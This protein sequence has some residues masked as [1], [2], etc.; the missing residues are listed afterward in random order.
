MAYKLGAQQHI[1][2]GTGNALLINEV[3]QINA[4]DNKRKQAAFPQYKYPNVKWRYG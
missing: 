4:I 3:I 1:A 2:H